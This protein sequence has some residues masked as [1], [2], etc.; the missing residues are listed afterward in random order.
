V[1]VSSPKRKSLRDRGGESTLA[2]VLEELGSRLSVVQMTIKIRRN[3]T[4]TFL[5]HE[6]RGGRRIDEGR[7][8]LLLVPILCRSSQFGSHSNIADKSLFVTGNRAGKEGWERKKKKTTKEEKRIC[9]RKWEGGNVHFRGRNKRFGTV[10]G[11]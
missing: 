2:W 11:K 1:S 3:G 8:G 9:K 6:R 5:G 7:K 10:G 4:R